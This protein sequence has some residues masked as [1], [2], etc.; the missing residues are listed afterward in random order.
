[1]VVDANET[2]PLKRIA[3][4]NSWAEANL[5]HTLRMWKTHATERGFTR[6]AE[7][8]D[9]LQ[10][11]E[12]TH[13]KLATKWIRQLTDDDPTHRDE[14]VRWG[15]DVIIGMQRFWAGNPNAE[16]DESQVH[17]SFLRSN[18]EDVRGVPA[19]MIGE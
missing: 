8:A 12:L 4:T 7:L 17:F 19:G 15:R 14:L 16:P 3:V 1:V 9:Y 18:S 6:I 5:M 10:A 2:D 13:V 11:D